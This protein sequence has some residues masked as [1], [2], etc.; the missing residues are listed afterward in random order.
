MPV[1]VSGSIAPFLA[2]CSLPQH[3]PR[4]SLALSLSL[5]LHFSPAVA[6]YLSIFPRV[7][8]KSRS[9]TSLLMPVCCCRFAS[10]AAKVAAEQ[11]EVLALVPALGSCKHGG[12]NCPTTAGG[13]E[14]PDHDRPGPA[15]AINVLKI[16]V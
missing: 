2:S 8:T 5:Y 1:F 11:D 14:M 9:S 16:Q 4:H 6:L 3:T 15:R 13:I 10:I 7:E 12:G